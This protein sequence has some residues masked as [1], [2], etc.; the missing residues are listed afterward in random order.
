MSG[1]SGTPLDAC[2]VTF[3]YMQEQ[4]VKLEAQLQAALSHNALQEAQIAGMWEDSDKRLNF[5]M[6]WIGLVGTEETNGVI[7]YYMRFNH[8][9]YSGSTWRECIDAAM[10]EAK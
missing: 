8:K 6:D 1:E 9:E 7:R 10:R 2:K 4:V 3:L 5:A